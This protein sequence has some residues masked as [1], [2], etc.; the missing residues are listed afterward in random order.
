[1]GVCNALPS[2]HRHRLL[3][4]SSSWEVW[5]QEE[6]SVRPAISVLPVACM[7]HSKICNTMDAD[8]FAALPRCLWVLGSAQPAAPELTMVPP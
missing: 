8:V 7:L 1:M 2:R 5:S 4:A 3:R 6:H